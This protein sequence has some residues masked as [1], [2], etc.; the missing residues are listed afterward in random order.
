MKSSVGGIRYV[1]RSDA[2]PLA[3]AAREPGQAVARRH[4]HG[5]RDDDDGHDHDQ[6]V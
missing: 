4:R 2:E 5:N 3:P 1:K 6:G